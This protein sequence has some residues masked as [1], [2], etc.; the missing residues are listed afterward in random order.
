MEYPSIQNKNAVS[1]RSYFITDIAVLLFL[2]ISTETKNNNHS[3]MIK[4]GNRLFHPIQKASSKTTVLQVRCLHKN[5]G[6]RLS[7]CHSECQLHLKSQNTPTF[8]SNQ[9]SPLESIFILYS[10]SI[11]QYTWSRTMGILHSSD[12]TLKICLAVLSHRA[13]K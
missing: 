1:L 5:L 13:N 12:S 2:P 10:K 8:Y 7:P 6:K 11:L 9:A 4:G 3:C